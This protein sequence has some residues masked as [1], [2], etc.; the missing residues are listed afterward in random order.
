MMVMTKMI[1]ISIYIGI[2]SSE[3]HLLAKYLFF[4]LKKNL[5]ISEAEKLKDQGVVLH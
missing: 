4:H 2:G 5:I 1:V 3:I